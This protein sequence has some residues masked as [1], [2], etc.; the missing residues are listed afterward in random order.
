M[1]VRYA[2][3]EFCPAV[4]LVTDWFI[5]GAGVLNPSGP[6]ANGKISSILQRACRTEVVAL[7]VAVTVTVKPETVQQVVVQLMPVSE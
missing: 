3:G 4:E 6:K 5:S 1:L 7:F 2:T